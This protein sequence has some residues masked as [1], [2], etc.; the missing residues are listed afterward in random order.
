MTVFGYKYSL[1]FFSYRVIGLAIIFG[2]IE[3]DREVA[4]SRDLHD[5][6]LGYLVILSLCLVLEAVIACVSLRGGILDSEPRNSM[7][8]LLYAR[9]RKC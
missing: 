3:F 1:L 7:Q 8:Y 2:L 6:I 9:L 4:C 5:H